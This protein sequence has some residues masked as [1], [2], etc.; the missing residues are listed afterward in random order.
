MNGFRTLN[1]SNEF[2]PE[3]ADTPLFENK[4]C[5]S[6]SPANGRNGKIFFMPSALKDLDEHISWG[7]NLRE[8][9][10]EQGG[11]MLGNVYRDSL[12]G[13]L[14]A[15]VLRL[16]PVYGAEGTP[17]YLYMGTDASFDA[18]IR[19][20]EIIQEN[21]NSL[22][23][24]GWYHTHPGSLSVFMSGTDR[25][26]QTKCYYNEWQFAVVLN[27]QKQ[28]WRGFRGKEVTEV[29]CIMV[30]DQEDPVVRKFIKKHQT[31]HNDGLRTYPGTTSM[32]SWNTQANHP[33]TS[34]SEKSLD[35]MLEDNSI[36][37]GNYIMATDTFMA[38]LYNSITIKKF[39]VI[40][41]SIS[42]DLLLQIVIDEEQFEISTIICSSQAINITE[43]KQIITQ[44]D[45]QYYSDK[46]K[47]NFIHAIVHYKKMIT[48]DEEKEL[49]DYY[50]FTSRNELICIFSELS[51]DYIQF[52][53]CDSDRN[54]YKG[55]LTR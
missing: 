22:R 15:I 21:N 37:I 46:V 45:G 55:E 1:V 33:Q 20:N 30:C 47:N 28:I 7:Q 13:T 44:F 52:Y 35:V 43:K 2:I 39:K 11:Y 38:Q 24:V 19:E 31:Y 29:D 34:S 32:E 53:V 41:D 48:E 42:L 54:T 14:F 17:T 9:L 8:N 5:S 16:V 12:T 26:T 27:P 3:S 50:E 25:K 4:I 36:Y 40:T 23:R 49:T 10:V 51:N 6:S 18:T